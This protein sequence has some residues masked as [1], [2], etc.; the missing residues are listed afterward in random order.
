M[1]AR[2]GCGRRRRISLA[3]L[4]TGF[5][6]AFSSSESGSTFE[7]SL[8]GS[9]FTSCA[10]PQSYAALGAGSHTFEVRATDPAGNTD[11]SPATHTWTIT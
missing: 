7:C 1:E 10:T 3:A 9:P 5:V 11:P 4:R 2:H 6:V 8:D